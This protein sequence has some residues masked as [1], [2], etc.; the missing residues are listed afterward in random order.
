MAGRL[1][2]RTGTVQKPRDASRT[3]STLGRY[4]LQSTPMLVLALSLSIAGNVFQLIG[5]T[6]CGRAIDAVS[7]GKGKVDF[8]TVYYYAIRMVG[9][10]VASAVLAYIVPQIVL[11][12]SQRTVRTMRVDLF[13]KLMRLPVKYFDTHQMGETLSRISY[14]IDTVNTSLSNDLVQ[15][16]TS[17]VTVVGALVMMIKISPLLV[18]VFVVTVPLSVLFTRFMTRRVRPL[19]HNRS[20]CLGAMNGFAEEYIS[21]QKTIR[22]YHREEEVLARFDEKNED[23]VNSYY[24]AEY[25]ASSTGPSVNFINNLS[26]TLISIFGALMYLN[27]AITV[28]NISSFVLYS[29]KFSGP[30]NE[31]ANI[32][33]ELQSALAAA[34]RVFELL[35]EEEETSDVPGALPLCVERGE[36]ELEHVDFGYDPAKIILKDINL[37][38]KPGNMIAIVGPTG[39]GKTTIVNLLM[40]FYDPQKGEIRIDDQSIYRVTRKSLRSSFSMVLQDTW[41]FNGTVHDNIAY[42]NPGATREAVIAA[43]KA[44]HIHG[45]ITRLPHGYDTIIT[46]DGVNISKGQKQLMTIARAMLQPA[47]LLILDEATSNVD[48]QTELLIQEA[49][50]TLM[51]DKTCFVIA[52]RLSTIRNAD[53]ILVVNDGKIVEQGTHEALLEDNGFYASLYRAQFE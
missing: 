2:T 8:D 44:A 22:A 19:Y 31:A 25:Y 23:A 50:R 6:L 43:A 48:L 3:L 9:F 37:Q 26:L 5:P 12:I 16:L 32:F 42:G 51:H 15:I 17:I 10:Y 7:G 40:R 34:E 41:L 28:G 53:L 35:N 33:S 47:H 21:G 46:E 20:K 39:A 18:T 13:S 24:K 4:L 38:A 30:I 11:R 52:H 14:D 29:R 45:M 27:G 1:Q 49:M 36:V